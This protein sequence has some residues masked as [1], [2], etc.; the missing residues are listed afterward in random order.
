MTT[1]G[2]LVAFV[3]LAQAHKPLSRALIFALDWL[4]LERRIPLLK[5]DAK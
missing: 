4:E 2:I 1:L 5:K 3:L